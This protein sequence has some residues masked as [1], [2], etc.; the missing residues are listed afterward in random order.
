VCDSLTQMLTKISPYLF[1]FVMEYSLIVLGMAAIMYGA[2]D[3]DMVDSFKNLKYVLKL[4]RLVSDNLDSWSIDSSK[5]KNSNVGAFL[6]GL[7]IT[8][9]ISSL[10]AAAVQQGYDDLKA[11]LT[12]II[13]DI[14]FNIT[15]IVACFV[16]FI[17]LL[18]NFPRVDRNATIDDI[19]LIIAMTG[20]L[21]FQLC[22]IIPTA[23]YLMTSEEE[24]DSRIVLYLTLTSSVLAMIEHLFQTIVILAA[25]R[26]YS[27]S[28]TTAM[29]YPARQILIFLAF[30]N[31]SMWVY[32]T[33][34]WQEL[35]AIVQYEF[36]VFIW[37]F[38]L[39]LN[40]PFLLF[41]HFH[42]SVCFVDIW[43]SA[44]RPLAHR[45]EPCIV[46]VDAM[47]HE[48]TLVPHSSV[49][50]SSFGD[51]QSILP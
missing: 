9:M 41:F 15:I 38:L 20:A 36:S 33:M 45:M 19:L 7:F 2:L 12:Y 18:K 51:S 22:V 39:T 50:N 17:K 13:A 1:P 6:G 47:K 46:D 4:S 44:Y 5:V 49:R 32:H 42:S 26:T 21:F 25:M 3:A 8:L 48:S 43:H 27:E 37:V 10:I 14:C 40:L 30:C 11:S 23:R 29:K 28:L 35:Q 24:E 34:Q 16:A 31:V